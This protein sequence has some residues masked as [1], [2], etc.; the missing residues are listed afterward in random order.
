[1]TPHGANCVAI[2]TGVAHGFL[3]LEDEAALMYFVGTEYAPE[4]DAG[5]LWNSFSFD[6]PVDSVGQNSPTLSD[7]DKSHP[8][9]ANFAS[10]DQWEIQK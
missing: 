7:R 10:P 8:T 4:A 5:V 6:W 3:A 1:M 9:L 2:P